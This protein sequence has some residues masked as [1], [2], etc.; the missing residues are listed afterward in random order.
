[1]QEEEV[2]AQGRPPH[3]RHRLRVEQVGGDALEAHLGPAP[4]AEVGNTREELPPLA[5]LRASGAGQG[6][7][8]DPPVRA[9]APAPGG[10]P[11]TIAA[12]YM[13]RR[14]ESTDFCSASP[15]GSSSASRPSATLRAD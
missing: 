10:T 6:S 7:G 8:G 3:K 11:L 4:A 9:L 12:M 15:R 2:E 5:S 13:L 1:M 14:A